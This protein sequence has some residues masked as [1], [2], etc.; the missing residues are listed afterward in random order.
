VTAMFKWWYHFDLVVMR[1]ENA[2]CGLFSTQTL[3][4]YWF[5]DIFKISVLKKKYLISQ[6]N[7]CSHRTCRERFI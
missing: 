2:S 6:N 4:L 1:Q 3:D 5:F 7:I